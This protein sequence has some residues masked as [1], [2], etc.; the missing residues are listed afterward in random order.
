MRNDIDGFIKS[1]SICR[2]VLNNHA[3]EKKKCLRGNH[4]EEY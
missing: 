4:S 2:K 1:L 3:Q